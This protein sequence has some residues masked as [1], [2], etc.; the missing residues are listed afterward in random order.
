MTESTNALRRLIASNTSAKSVTMSARQVM[1]L[2]A[3]VEDME[4]EI[5]NMRAILGI[6]RSGAGGVPPA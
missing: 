2:I 1:A 5:E 3:E 6:R 4:R